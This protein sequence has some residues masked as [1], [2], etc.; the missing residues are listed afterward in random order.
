MKVIL[1]H[2]NMNYLGNRYGAGDALDITEHFFNTHQTR[3]VKAVKKQVPI[4]VITNDEPTEKKSEKKKDSKKAS[5]ASKQ[6]STT[7]KAA[8]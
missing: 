8:E 6:A 1:K 4:K 2:G 3:F 7:K 5:P